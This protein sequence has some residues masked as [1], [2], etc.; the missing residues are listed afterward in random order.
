MRILVLS[1]KI[2][3]PAIDGGSI[4]TLNLILSLA[5]LGHEVH[6]LTMNT[7][8]HYFPLEKIPE[9]IRKKLNLI[10]LD[11]PAKISFWSLLKNSL[12]SKLP[13]TAERFFDSNFQ[14]TLV[15]LLKKY[16]F[17]IIQL[18]GLYLGC[19]IPM[20]QKSTSAKII[21]RAHNLEFEIWKRAALRSS[22][23]KRI[24]LNQL[25]NRLLNFEKKLLNDYAAVLPISKK[26]GEWYKQQKKNLKIH[27]LP[28]GLSAEFESVQLKTGKP[29]D[30][31]HIG[32]LDWLPNQEG[33]L[34]FFKRVWPEIHQKHPD[35][36]F[37]L[38]GRNA[39]QEIKNLKAPNLIFKGE[40]ES[41]LE[42]M[43]EHKLMIVPLFSGSGMRIKIIE[44]MALGKTIISTEL[45]L[46]GNSAQKDKEVLIANTKEEFIEKIEHL[47]RHPELID[48]IGR[49]AQKFARK[50]F[51]QSSIAQD[52][53][54][55]YQQV[56]D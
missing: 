47:F 3:Y 19:Y 26:D 56:L 11:V 18:E 48:T 5:K 14:E 45:G 36:K 2:P 42:F 28:A 7:K 12:F 17:D 30:L 51:N 16:R 35:L 53:E 37:Y 20:I 50:H 55:F 39:S 32:A 6:L 8:K 24:Y 34:W 4:A 10:A 22:L 40:V 9:P 21:Y 27:H 41:A 49:A 43:Q 33:L 1:N 44:G 46:E 52:L 54:T 25:S 13:Y 15:D 31:F 23:F 38:A 29:I